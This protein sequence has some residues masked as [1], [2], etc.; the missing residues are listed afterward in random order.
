VLD[1]V[2]EVQA[3]EERS[4]P[5]PTAQALDCGAG[6][7]VAMV[8]H[9]DRLGAGC[10]PRFRGL[11]G[12]NRLTNTLGWFGRSGTLS[13]PSVLRAAR[14]ATARLTVSGP[15]LAGRVTYAS[16]AH[17]V[18]A[19][20]VVA[21]HLRPAPTVRAKLEHRRRALTRTTLQVALSAHGDQTRVTLFGAFKRR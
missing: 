1:A 16:A 5:T 15:R 7:D 18:H 17:H 13:I 14:A 21:A 19:G 4:A 11:H 12:D 3:S 2:T 20:G 10:G 9:S 6:R 8:D